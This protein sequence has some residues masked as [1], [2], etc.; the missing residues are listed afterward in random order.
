M[1]R[2]IKK[3]LKEDEFVDGFSGLV[4]FIQKWKKELIIAAVVVVGLA[5]LWTGVQV[6][7]GVQNRKNSAD[8]GEILAL[9][10]DLAKNPQNL[11]KLEVLARKGKF[12]RVASAQ[13]ASYW[14]EQGALDKADKALAGLSGGPRD[15]FYYQAQDM[16]GQIAI[17]KGEYD[18][19]VKILQAIEEAKPGDYNIDTVLYHE[20]EA[21]EKKGDRAAALALYKRIQTEYA[22]SYFGYD[23]GQKIH[24]LEGGK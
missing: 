20:A 23:A 14:V 22:Q 11:S 5:V 4:D 9:R 6:L 12:A 7:N 10:N 2:D 15:F 19:A 21:L 8:L 24:K 16:A 17:L 13:L 1:K 18:R 3:K